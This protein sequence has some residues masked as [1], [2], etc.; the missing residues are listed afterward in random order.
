M[1]GF[2]ENYID[3]KLF[4]FFPAFCMFVN[5]GQNLHTPFFFFCPHSWLPIA[6]TLA[7]ASDMPVFK[8]APIFYWV[9]NWGAFPEVEASYKG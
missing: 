4:F 9:F 8:N 1:Y 2:N 5:V 7:G 3:K 6:I